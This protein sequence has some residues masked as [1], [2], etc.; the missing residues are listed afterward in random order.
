MT[1]SQKTFFLIL[2]LM[3]ASQ[4]NGDQLPDTFGNRLAAAKR[5]LDVMPTELSVN[6]IIKEN[7]KNLPEQYQSTYIKW[8]GEQIDID[9][10]NIAMLTSMA[11]NFTVKELNALAAFYGSPEG[12]SS[13]RKIGKYMADVMPLILQ[14]IEK[15]NKALKVKLAK[16]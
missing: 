12:R 3:L 1:I 4:V 10:L 2:I 13:M 16:H 15:A 6:E 11:K 5:Y 7:A 9:S 14:E 8:I